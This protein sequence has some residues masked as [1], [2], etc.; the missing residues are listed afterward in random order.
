M[1]SKKERQLE[2]WV[3]QQESFVLLKSYFIAGTLDEIDLKLRHGDGQI[4]EELLFVT[5]HQMNPQSNLHLSSNIGDPNQYDRTYIWTGDFIAIHD[6][7]SR[8]AAWR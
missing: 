3:K 8:L 1:P 6:Q 4:P 5:P 7:K 2:L